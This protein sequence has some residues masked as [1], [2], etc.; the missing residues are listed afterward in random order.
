VTTGRTTDGR[1]ARLVRG[2]PTLLALATVALGVVDIV[3]ALTPERAGR[4]RALTT[5]VP[6]SVAHAASAGAA[7]AGLL[8]VLLGLGLRR[9][10]RRAWRAAVVL[11]LTSTAL[12]V[13]KGLDGEEAAVTFTLAVVLL[14]LSRQFYAEG[15]PTTRWRA[16]VTFVLMLA[17]S[18]VL[19]LGLL[20]ARNHSLLGRPSLGA[21]AQEVVWGLIGVSGPV[22][23]RTEGTSDLVFVM[24]LGFGA[25]TALVTA[26]LALR[27]PEPRA[28]LS[29]DDVVRLRAL[30]GKHGERDSLGYFALRHDK[31]VIFSETGKAAVSYRVVSG[32]MLAI[33][34]HGRARSARLSM[35]RA[36]THGSRRSW[37]AASSA[38][39]CGCARPTCMRS[40]WATKR[41]STSRTSPSRDER[42]ATSAR[43]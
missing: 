3:S 36:A 6:L 16:P 20:Y 19:G 18:F 29:A 34:R 9:R 30:L 23:F 5:V 42:C 39:R 31:A 25:A 35:R 12:H 1:S 38:A 22:R 13:V 27:A 43:W 37:G 41:S 33:R 15:D 2:V 8:L 14:V 21:R 24:L 4:L 32:V 7:V 10:K 28:S 17:A 26:Y 40:N 11:L